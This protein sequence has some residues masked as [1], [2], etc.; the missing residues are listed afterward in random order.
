MFTRRMERSRRCGCLAT[1]AEAYGDL[2]RESQGS[3]A[4]T[5][6]RFMHLLLRIFCSCPISVRYSLVLFIDFWPG[7]G[8]CIKLF[9][10]VFIRF[11]HELLCTV[12]PE[13]ST[14][15]L[16]MGTAS[17]EFRVSLRTC[18]VRVFFVFFFRD[19]EHG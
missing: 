12:G 5:D 1:S 9:F 17:H 15:S 16:N 7:H 19:F 11:W 18:C 8:Y 6:A 2:L 14:G 4:E 3:K 13:L 10:I